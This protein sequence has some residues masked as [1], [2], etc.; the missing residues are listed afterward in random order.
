MTLKAI[1]CIISI[2][3]PTKSNVEK[4]NTVVITDVKTGVTTSIVPSR[5]DCIGDFPFSK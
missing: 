5:A 2:C 4:A 1:S 3:P